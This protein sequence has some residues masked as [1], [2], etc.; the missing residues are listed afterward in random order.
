M[1]EFISQQGTKFTFFVS[2][3]PSKCSQDICAAK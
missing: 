3:W 2:S 1:Q